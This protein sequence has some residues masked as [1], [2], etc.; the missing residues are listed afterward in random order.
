M[1]QVTEPK[2]FNV[3]EENLA[4]LQ[5]RIAKLNKRAKKLSCAAITV[6]ILGSKEVP[7]RQHD[8]LGFEADRIVG[9]RKVYEITV[10]GQAPKINGWEFIA[11]IQPTMDEAGNN[12]G[13]ILRG[14]PGASHEVPEAYRKAENHCDHC[15]TIR[16]RNETFVLRHDD[17]T[18]KQVGRNCLRDFLGHTSPE[19]LA[20]IAQMLIDAEDF[21]YASE[22]D[23]FGGRSTPRYVAEEVLRLAACSIRLNG[24]RSNKTAREFGK[25][26]TSMEVS[27]WINCRAD[28]RKKW[29][30]PLIVSDE[31]KATAAEVTEWLSKL[32]ERTELNDYMYNLSI[33][34]QG[35][36]FTS[37]NFGLACSAIPTY[38]REMEREI[39]RRKQF[40][41]DAKSEHIGTVGVKFEGWNLTLVHTM[42][43]SSDWGVSHMYKFKDATGNVV[44]WF[45]SKVYYNDAA[46]RDINVGDTVILSG[47]VKAHENYNGKGKSLVGVKQTI[48]TRC[49]TYV[50]PEQK[51][52]IAKARREQR[53]KMTAAGCFDP[54]SPNFRKNLDEIGTEVQF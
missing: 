52:A 2:I 47:S 23:G 21:G 6:N 11:V 8:E 4:V 45:S 50:S 29:E 27:A 13:N 17:D 34:G 26:S 25:E 28:E 32:Q 51:K 37:K 15:N 53:E 16:R 5:E 18:Y 30:K 48:V 19:T 36:T 35:A 31:D 12:L 7:I 42:D 41:D 1:E 44:V 24:W 22:N 49:K 43:F 9:Y 38:L 33:L 46:G 54:N 39:N 40:E 14:V 10:I 20:A 3:P